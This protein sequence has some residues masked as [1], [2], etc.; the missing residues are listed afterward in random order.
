MAVRNG[1]FTIADPNTETTSELFEQ[2]AGLVG[3]GPRSDGKIYLSDICVSDGID[4]WAKY[5]SIRSS[6]QLNITEEERARQC[7]GLD[8]SEIFATNHENALNMALANDGEYYYLKPRGSAVSP[9][10]WF[11]IRDFNGYNSRA[12]IPYKY[13]LQN[14]PK[15]KANW[16]DVYLNPKGELLLSEIAPTEISESIRNYKIAL[17]YRRRNTSV[18]EGVISTS[19]IADVEAGE[20]PIIYFSLENAGVYDMV[21]AITNAAYLDQ[22][23]AEWIYLPEAVFTASYDPSITSFSI[24]YNEDNALVGVTENGNPISSPSTQVMGVHLDMRLDSEDEAKEGNLIIEFNSEYSGS[25]AWEEEIAYKKSFELDTYDSAF[26]YE[27]R[28]P[29]YFTNPY[30]DEIYVKARVE[31]RPRYSIDKY[32]VRYIDLTTFADPLKVS[33]K[34]FA[35][36]T[37]KQIIDNRNW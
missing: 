3:V 15:T 16:I 27:N 30:V 34:E 18:I 23:D 37:L 20:Q 2:L 7:Y 29:Y 13:T 10:E 24:W 6:T 28:L 8:I 4:I 17:V 25:G 19:T 12:E 35:P 31:Y 33:D 26:F 22:E 9:T 32:D 36:V 5:K 1:V 21:L 14:D 11:R